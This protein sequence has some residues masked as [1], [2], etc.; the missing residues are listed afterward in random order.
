MISSLEVG[1]VFK[2]IDEASPTLIKIS[3]AL[4]EMQGLVD[5][6]KESFKLLSQS[7]FGGLA[8]RIDELAGS[9]GKVEKS[10]TGIAGNLD[11]AMGSVA[12]SMTSVSDSIG[13]LTSRIAALNTELANTERTA[14]RTAEV[15]AAG[16]GSGLT[17]LRARGTGGSHGGGSGGLH[18]RAM[19]AGPLGLGG[20]DI[21]AAGGLWS[22]YEALKAAADLQEVQENLKISGVSPAE[23]QKATR[24]AYSIGAQYGLTATSVL[25]GINEIR[26]PLNKGKTADEGVEDALRHADTLAR[27]AVVLRDQGK[28]RNGDVGRELYDLVKSAEF[29]NAIGDKD[30]DKAVGSMVSADVATGGIVTPRTFLQMSQMLKGALPGLSDDYLYKIMPELSQEFGGARAG[31]AATSL[32]QQLIAGQMRTTGL[33]PSRSSRNGRRKQGRVRQERENRSRATGFLQGRGH[34]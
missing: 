8:G 22:A 32:Y 5:R 31:T 7:T 28:D 20:G 18:G 17:G 33:A 6:T 12:G 34:L 1:G 27:A 19:H 25:Q 11:K 24:E 14:A 30:F 9:L 16:G 21:A 29:R 3:D 15:A 10:S 13:T 2:I 4:K 26:N 23:I